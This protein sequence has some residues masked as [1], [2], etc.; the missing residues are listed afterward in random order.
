MNRHTS[1]NVTMQVAL[2]DL[3]AQLKA[4][5]QERTV[6]KAAE[7]VLLAPPV[8]TTRKIQPDKQS[9]VRRGPLRSNHR[10]RGGNR[11]QFV[12]TLREQ[13]KQH[14]FESMHGGERK[15][16]LKFINTY[17]TQLV[18]KEQTLQSQLNT[19]STIYAMAP[20]SNRESPAKAMQQHGRVRLRGTQEPPSPKEQATTSPQEEAFIQKQIECGLYQPTH[21]RRLDAHDSDDY[22]EFC[23]TYKVVDPATDM[24]ICQTCMRTTEFMENDSKNLAFGE[25]IQFTKNIAYERINHFRKWIATIQGQERTIV[26]KAV[27]QKVEDQ[28]YANSL[29]SK[30][31]SDINVETIKYYL[32]K[33]SQSKYYANAPQ[34]ERILTGRS[35][36]TFTQKE[37]NILIS[38]FHQYLEPFEMFKKDKRVNSLYYGYL[39]YKF[40]ELQSWFQ[41]LPYLK[42]WRLK[43]EDCRAEQDEIWKQIC[44]YRGWTYIE[45]PIA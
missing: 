31:N 32:R 28:I 38:M 40:C 43:S 24:Y 8:K 34:I 20:V 45:T 42:R 36:L 41:Y 4:L 23:K 17:L 18:Q 10:R 27:I 35:V 22:C 39:L 15:V 1:G 13:L 29:K 21:I 11:V 26:P 7:K 14:A 44:E 5:I 9:V 37:V 6:L 33:T 2:Y 19:V 16:L 12:G 25:R 3:K 30:D